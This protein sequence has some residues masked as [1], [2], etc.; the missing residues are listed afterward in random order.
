MAMAGDVAAAQAGLDTMRRRL[1][2]HLATYRRAAGLSQPELGRAVGRTR[3]MVSKIEHGTRA[4]PQALWTVTDEVC[5]AE[6]ALIA[7]HHTLAQAEQDYRA[8]CRAQ[9]AQVQQRHAQAQLAALKA[10]SGLDLVA[11]CG[12]WPD[13]T[14]ADG[15]LARELMAVVTKLVRSIGR[16]DAEKSGDV[17]GF[18]AMPTIRTPPPPRESRSDKRVRTVAMPV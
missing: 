9:R 8:R 6:G 16:R 1:G 4:M 15:E 2:A 7:E 12:V 18:F 3:S 13:M 10:S 14:G 17:T 11:G 5:H